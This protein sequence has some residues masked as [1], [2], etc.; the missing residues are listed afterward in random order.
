MWPFKRKN[1]KQ[2]RDK[3]DT[4]EVAIST[5]Y[6]GGHKPPWETNRTWQ[7]ARR[8]TWKHLETQA[9][10]QEAYAR[11]EVDGLEPA[12]ALCHRVIAMAPVAIEAFRVDDRL[13]HETSWDGKKKEPVPPFRAPTNLGFKQLAIIREKEKNYPEAI[14]L[15]QEAMKQGW[16]GDWDVRIARCSRKMKAT[17]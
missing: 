2:S 17:K 13:L 8:T 6:S 9:A 12:V 1:T 7:E 5:D 3:R 11:R 16:A 4:I 14:A 15:C 10:M